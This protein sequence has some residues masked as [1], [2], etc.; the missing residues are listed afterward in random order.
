MVH[1]YLK[2]QFKDELQVTDGNKNTTEK[3]L[4]KKVKPTQKVKSQ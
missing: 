1:Y 3:S 4:R 2:T